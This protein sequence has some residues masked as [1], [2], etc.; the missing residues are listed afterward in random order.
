MALAFAGASSASATSFDPVITI[1][2]PQ[3]ER[4]IAL[5]AAAVGDLNGDGRTD[6][7]MS[8]T[9]NLGFFESDEDYKIHLYEQG[10]DGVLHLARSLP[11]SWE[12]QVRYRLEFLTVADLDADGL[13]EIL[14]LSGSDIVMLGRNSD[15]SYGERTRF[16]MP[17]WVEFSAGIT[18]PGDIDGDGNVDIVL[19]ANGSRSPRMC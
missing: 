14:L 1:N 5:A 8:V 16:A 12:G 4:S 19:H 11:A 10:S 13:A 3:N 2:V 17:S 18:H 6:L 7:V 15:G 9:N